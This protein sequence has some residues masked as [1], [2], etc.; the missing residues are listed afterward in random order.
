M[1]FFLFGTYSIVSSFSLSI[2]V[3]FCALNRTATSP[4]LT[5]SSHVG[6]ELHQSDCPEFLIA[7]QTFVIAQAIFFVLY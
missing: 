3:N 4:T 5:D 7:S 2:C 6:D 1:G